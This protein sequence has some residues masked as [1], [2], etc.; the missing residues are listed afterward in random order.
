MKEKDLKKIHDS[1][2]ENKVPI[3][4]DDGMEFLLD[5][6]R[7]HEGIRDILEVGTAVGYSAIRM[8]SLRWDMRIDTLEVNEDMY[9]QAVENIRKE[10][11]EARIHVHLIDA[12][13]FET[14]RIY[15]LIFIDAAKSQYRRYQEH[16]L[17]NAR[18]GTV[19][20]YDNL[21]FHG[22]VD[23]NALSKNRSTIQMM[24]KIKKFRDHLLK[25]D[26]FDTVFHSNTGD[27]VAVS[28]L[29]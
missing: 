22:I 15:D 29:K 27:G 11:L 2:R 14:D 13:E 24:H 20:I 17:K 12:A 23:D 6:I 25:D 26:R 28:I 21:N 19:F 16:F 8:A 4:L 3:M 7:Q 18:E 10:G 1:A 5:Y 9:R